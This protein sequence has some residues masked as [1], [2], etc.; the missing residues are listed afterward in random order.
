MCEMLEVCMLVYVCVGVHAFF[1]PQQTPFNLLHFQRLLPSAVHHCDSRDSC[2]G[3]RW[4]RSFRLP[5]V[6][7]RNSLESPN[8]SNLAL[9]SSSHDLRDLSTCNPWPLMPDSAT[10]AQK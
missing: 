1:S 4:K 10:Y 7:D 2:R 3:P 5:P 8:G 9:T 6:M